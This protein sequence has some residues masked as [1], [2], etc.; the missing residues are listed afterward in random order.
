MRPNIKI[1]RI[2]LIPLA[3]ALVLLMGLGQM[4]KAQEG[5]Q[6]SEWGRSERLSNPGG[7]LGEPFTAPIYLGIYGAF[8]GAFQYDQGNT[9]CGLEFIMRPGA[10]VKY[11]DSLYRRNI[12]VVLQ[13]EYMNVG[14]NRRIL[15]GDFILRRY[16][17]DMR[18]PKSKVAP[19]IGL[20][21]GA[22]EI[23][24]QP[25]DGQGID[26]Y[27]CGVF[28]AGQE[29]SITHKFIV[30]VKCQYRYYNYHGVNYSNWSMI[31]GVGV[32]VPW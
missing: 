13:A 24:L 15:S 29:W 6:F 2:L 11:F 9:G 3:L 28:E 30:Q 16:F 26:K 17:G 8:G 18:Y 31:S 23:T 21:F 25:P 5:P 4:T 12:G 14:A 7:A 32:P 27:W 1:S 19:F 22:S 20:G 10:A